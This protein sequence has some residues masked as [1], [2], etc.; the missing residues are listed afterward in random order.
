M[1]F[2]C[3]VKVRF[4]D[5]DNAGIVYYPRFFHYFHVAF[6]EMFSDR[7]GIHYVDVLGRE[8]IGFPAVKVESEFKAPLRFGDV[9]DVEVEVERIG[10]KSIT[11]RYTLRRGAAGPVCAT[12][13][14]TVATVDMDGFRAIPIP[15]KYRRLF[16]QV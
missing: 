1:G 6:E 16:E 3:A 4:A 8:R 15:E 9:A 11:C 2:H 10:T 5:V 14:V 7:F 12:G 13:R